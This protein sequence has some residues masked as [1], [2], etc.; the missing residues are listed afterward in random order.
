MMENARWIRRP[1]GAL[2]LVVG[3]EE[4]RKANR[5]VL[6]VVVVAWVVSD[7]TEAD[8]F[9]I[10]ASARSHRRRMRNSSQATE[11]SWVPVA[12]TDLFLA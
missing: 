10:Y 5:C 9:S 12:A 6:V 11:A 1:K 8:P 3:E 7:T 4:E 2:V